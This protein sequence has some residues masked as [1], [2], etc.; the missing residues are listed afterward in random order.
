M[1]VYFVKA[2]VAVKI[3]YTEGHL[4]SRLKAVQQYSACEIELLC[5]VDGGRKEENRVHKKFL[6]LRLRGDWYA[7]TPE[8][9]E[10]AKEVS[11]NG[12][13]AIGKEDVFTE[14]A[15]R[16]LGKYPCEIYALC[17]E[18]TLKARKAGNRWLID[19]ES[20]DTFL[21]ETHEN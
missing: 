20:I 2:G 5:S 1:T 14:E 13:A 7:A 16:L 15:V 6:H 17:R 12:L 19:K 18:G 10:F 4:E 9:I 8:L 21:A 3:G 11:K